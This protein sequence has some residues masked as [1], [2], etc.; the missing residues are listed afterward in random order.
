MLGLK[1]KRENY[2]Y[3]LMIF[4]KNPSDSIDK[5]FAYFKIQQSSWIQDQFI[6]RLIL[7]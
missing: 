1:E 2:Y 6:H 5:I 7:K 3:F 4:I